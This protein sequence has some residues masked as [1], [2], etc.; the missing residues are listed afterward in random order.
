MKGDNTAI[1]SILVSY[2][3][4][5]PSTVDCGTITYSQ[6]INCEKTGVHVTLSECENS[7]TDDKSS[8]YFLSSIPVDRDCLIIVD[9]L[10][11]CHS[12]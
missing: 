4:Y 2:S 1:G 10:V 8:L 11:Q 9:T 5:C 12:T 7:A 6:G 3:S